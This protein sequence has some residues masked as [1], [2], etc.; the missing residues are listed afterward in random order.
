MI[1]DDENDRGIAIHYPNKLVAFG[2]DPHGFSSN[3][4]TCIIEYCP[5]CG[6]KVGGVES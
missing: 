4:V 3:G 5:M 6:V 2:Y 1:I